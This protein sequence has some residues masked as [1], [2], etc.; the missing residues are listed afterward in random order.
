MGK[1]MLENEQQSG[2]I[3]RDIILKYFTEIQAK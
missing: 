2:H 1:K 3:S